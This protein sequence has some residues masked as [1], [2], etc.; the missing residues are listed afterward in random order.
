MTG[1]NTALLHDFIDESREHLDEMESLLLQLGNDLGNLDLLNDIFRT[2]HNVKGA[3]QLTGLDRISRLSHRLEDLLDLLRQGHKQTTLV[4]VKLLISGRDQILKLV[5][6]LEESQQE[7]STVDELIDQ[8]N[9]LI[10]DDE[11]GAPGTEQTVTASTSVQE[12]VSVS[13]ASISNAKY[14]EENDK[15]LFNIFYEHLKEQFSL[16]SMASLHFRKVP[17]D[18]LY[19]LECKDAVNRLKSAANYMGYDEMVSFFDA[20]SVALEDACQSVLRGEMALLD[21]MDRNIDNLIST[22]PQLEDAREMDAVAMLADPAE[23]VVGSEEDITSAVLDVFREQEIKAVKSDINHSLIDDFIDESREHLDE[24]ESL[25]MQL[26]KD[27]GNL[28]ILND[29]FRTIHNIKGASQLTG[30]DKTTRLAHHLE[31]L[32]GLLRQGQIVSD[33]FIVEMLI[34][35]RDRIVLLVNEL[36]QSQQE[37]SSIEE[38]VEQLTALIEGTTFELSGS[39]AR[40]AHQPH[41]NLFATD[42]A[43]AEVTAEQSTPV[44]EPESASKEEPKP[45]ITTITASYFEEEN[46]QELFGIFISHLQE[47]LSYIAAQAM[48]LKNVSDR[49]EPLE[50]CIDI[51]NRLHSSANYMGYEELTRFYEIWKTALVDAIQA[52]SCGET[53]SLDFMDDYLGELVRIFPQLEDAGAVI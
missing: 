17:A 45:L 49:T 26:G 53:I 41:A 12:P 36:E 42:S 47:Q 28:D 30:L 25:L 40:D 23:E 32:L 3:S 48:Q 8:L 13:P 11:S 27:V 24:M 4:I 22:F 35:G 21:F 16:L 50:N 37:I 7:R 5:S 18:E 43:S 38:L 10:E 2:M 6:E 44:L 20:W 19:L 15:E 46:D 14:E 51:I 52:I 1:I 9:I 31:D 34:A 39:S 33:K 29:I